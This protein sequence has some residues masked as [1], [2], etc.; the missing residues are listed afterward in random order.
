ML[1]QLIKQWP[2]IA[3]SAQ[4]RKSGNAWTVIWLQIFWCRQIVVMFMTRVTASNRLAVMEVF[5][6]S[7]NVSLSMHV[8][9]L[10][11]QLLFGAIENF[12]KLFNH[13]TI[14]HSNHVS[15]FKKWLS[16][17]IFFHL[18]CFIRNDLIKKVWSSNLHLTFIFFK[19]YKLFSCISTKRVINDNLHFSASVHH[20]VSLFFYFFFYFFFTCKQISLD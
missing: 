6:W 2:W 13:F 1:S 20:G 10:N 15:C 19:M 7:D 4:Q 9:L 5:I 11:R 12:L 18:S 17:L 14:V 16:I 8:V 3:T